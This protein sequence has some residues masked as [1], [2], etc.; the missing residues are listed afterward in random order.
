MKK[1]RH[2]NVSPRFK[3]KIK[4]EER[5]SKQSNLIM[6]CLSN[7]TFRFSK[8][9]HIFLI[10]QSGC[11]QTH[12]KTIEFIKTR[13]LEKRTVFE[14]QNWQ[15]FRS[16]WNFN[17]K[18]LFN[19][20]IN[21]NPY[22]KICAVITVLGSLQ[23]KKILIYMCQLFIIISDRFLVNSAKKH[24]HQN[25]KCSFNWKRAVLWEN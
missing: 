25:K 16:E 17:R 21:I 1:I 18:I 20:K 10:F 2:W 7:K 12:G 14:T 15:S 8:I 23:S 22:L 13:V 11:R 4:L 19:F 6:N 3:L 9:V 24:L 5:F